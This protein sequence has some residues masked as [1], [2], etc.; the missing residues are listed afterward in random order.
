MHA[1]LRKA[2]CAV[3]QIRRLLE[4]RS[5]LRERNEHLLAERK[6]LREE[7]ERLRSASGAPRAGRNLPYCALREVGPD[8]TRMDKAATFR[9]PRAYAVELLEKHRQEGPPRSV[10]EIGGSISQNFST[11]VK[12][13]EY[14]N[15]DIEPSES[16][17]TIVADITEARSLPDRRFDFIYSNNTFEHISEPWV[18]AANIGKL[19]TP[20]GF[21]FVSTVFAWRYHPV[22]IDYWRFSPD[23]LAYLFRDLEKIEGN[24]SVAERRRD[25]RGFWPNKLD[26]PPA[27][28]LGGW[29][30]NWVSYFFGRKP[31][32]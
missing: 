10:L 29:R 30:E 17:P 28:V 26:A 32:P 21:V 13:A 2:A 14:Y 1:L 6:F 3:P 4:E 12:E 22:P 19:L 25:V 24:F 23:C 18:A 7:L 16:I 11:H 27:D 9:D 15:L 31:L 8:E 20:G 5:R